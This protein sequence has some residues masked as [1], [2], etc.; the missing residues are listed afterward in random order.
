M[1]SGQNL[2][3][4]ETPRTLRGGLAFTF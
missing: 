2:T 3:L 4:I 1:A